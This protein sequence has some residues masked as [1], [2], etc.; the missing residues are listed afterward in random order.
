MRKEEI[1]VVE[2]VWGEE[3]VLVNSDK[4]CGKLL[5]INEGS[6][7]SYHSHAVKEETFYILWGKVFLTV[8]D[9]GYVLDNSSAPITIE[10][11]DKHSTEGLTRA[12]I[13]EISTRHD[14]E[15]VFRLEESK[16]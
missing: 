4:Y 13:V 12:V 15:D 6:K 2:K 10:P 3:L 5:T 7:G 14:D 1:K 9:K 11:G 16:A 8:E